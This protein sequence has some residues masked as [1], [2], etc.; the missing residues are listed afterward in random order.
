MSEGEIQQNIVVVV[1]KSFSENIDAADIFS[2]FFHFKFYFDRV[3]LCQF[4]IV[5]LQIGYLN[6]VYVGPLFIYNPCF[7][8]TVLGAFKFPPVGSEISSLVAEVTGAGPCT[9]LFIINVKSNVTEPLGVCARDLRGQFYSQLKLSYRFLFVVGVVGKLVF[10]IAFFKPEKTGADSF[11]FQEGFRSVQ[12]SDDLLLVHMPQ[13]ALTSYSIKRPTGISTV[14]T[15]S[16]DLLL[17]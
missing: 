12:V 8:Q 16:S 3:V 9:N 6:P 15:S 14:M 1:S 13:G 5:N 17:S 2:I 7:E 11:G 4:Q 10:Y